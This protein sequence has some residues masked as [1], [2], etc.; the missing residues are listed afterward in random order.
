[1]RAAI[2]SSNNRSCGFTILFL[3][4]LLI[5]HLA[6]CE[7]FDFNRGKLEIFPWSEAKI[8]I[9]KDSKT[10]ANYVKSLFWIITTDEMVSLTFYI[11]ASEYIQTIRV[12]TWEYL[13]DGQEVVDNSEFLAIT[14]I[15]TFVAEVSEVSFRHDMEIVTRE[16]AIV[17]HKAIKRGRKE[18]ETGARELITTGRQLYVAISI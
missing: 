17:F 10:D 16:I 14:D 5:P 11:P 18:V 7:S 3:V 1:M 15:G 4:W 12:D 8:E 9:A 6:F 13:G 2:I